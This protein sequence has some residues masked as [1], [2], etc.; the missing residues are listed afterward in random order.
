MVLEYSIVQLHQCRLEFCE[1][2]KAWA[3]F[4]CDGFV[5]VCGINPGQGGEFPKYDFLV[6]LFGS[7]KGFSGFF[8]LFLKVIDCGLQF[9]DCLGSGD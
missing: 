7:G 2:R 5:E 3:S 8:L 1:C 9:G 6:G 4:A